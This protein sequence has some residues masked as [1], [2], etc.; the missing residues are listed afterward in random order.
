MIR[1]IKGHKIEGYFENT[2][3]A[4][5]KF[6]KEYNPQKGDGN[7]IWVNGNKSDTISREEEGLWEQRRNPLGFPRRQQPCRPKL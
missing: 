5:K 4:Q 1:D 3:E 2:K 7:L 6:V